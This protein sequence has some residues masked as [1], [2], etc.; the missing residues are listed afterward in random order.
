MAKYPL[1]PHTRV[2]FI[3][4][5]LISPARSIPLKMALDTGASITTIPIEAAIAIGCDPT[6]SKRRMEMITA[7]GIEYAPIVII[8]KIEFLG[9]TLR[10]VEVICHNLPPQ[11]PGSGLL[12][13]NVLKNFDV[14]LKFRSNILEIVE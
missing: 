2:I 3:E 10:N 4:V 8:P 9:F 11:S 14:L 1:D 6:K 5:R 7:S 13:L 12:G